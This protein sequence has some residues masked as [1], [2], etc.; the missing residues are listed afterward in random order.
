MAQNWTVS[1]EETKEILP[2]LS[3]TSGPDWDT[4][5]ND[6]KGIDYSV[7]SPPFFQVEGISSGIHLGT[8]TLSKPDFNGNC[9]VTGTWLNSGSGSEDART[10]V[11]LYSPQNRK[12]R[13]VS[14]T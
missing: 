10:V 5:C 9:K 6:M 4:L 1:R 7:D 14:I 2:V 11:L 3:I 8:E 12:G 13:V